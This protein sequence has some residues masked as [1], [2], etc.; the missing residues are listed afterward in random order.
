MVRL[1]KPELLATVERAIL[2]GGWRY[3]CLGPAV[4][5]P[6]RYSVFRGEQRYEACVYI[7]NLTPGEAA[8]PSAFY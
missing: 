6:A 8:V 7:W 5:H 2:D 3:L 4:D 1:A